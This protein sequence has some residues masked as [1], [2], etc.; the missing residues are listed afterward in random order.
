MKLTPEVLEEIKSQY[1]KVM[2]LEFDEDDY[3]FRYM[4][5]MEYKNYRKI[6]EKSQKL[7]KVGKS[8]EIE[9]DEMRKLIHGLCVFPEADVYQAALEIDGYIHEILPLNYIYHYFKRHAK[10]EAETKVEG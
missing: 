6:M 9:E 10:V 3:V 7:D 8:I 1:P 4:S 5:S 2:V